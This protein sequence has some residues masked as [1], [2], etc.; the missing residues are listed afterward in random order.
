MF[1]LI[2]K[3]NN[4]GKLPWLIDWLLKFFPK[5]FPCPVIQI[6]QFFSFLSPFW[7]WLTQIQFV[8]VVLL[9]LLEQANK[10]QQNR[11]DVDPIWNISYSEIHKQQQQKKNKIKKFPFFIHSLSFDW[12]FFWY[13]FFPL[14]YQCNQGLI[15]NQNKI[16]KNNNNRKS[17][18][19]SF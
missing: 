19:E 1:D 10:Q 16:N 5:T 14:P 17:K 12:F 11:F 2:N 3:R 4:S 15:S 6:G 7:F 8:V 9:L 13:R 18:F